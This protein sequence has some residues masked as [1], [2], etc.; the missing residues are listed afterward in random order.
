MTKYDL[1]I[2]GAGP[3][4]LTAAIYATRAGLSTLLVEK[5]V[6]GGQVNLANELENYPAEDGISG[7]EL[8]LKMKNQAEKYG[9]KFLFDEIASVDSSKKVVTQS[10]EEIEA[11]AVI[12]AVGTKHRELG[13]PSEQKFIG[14]GVSYCAVCDGGF[15]KNKPV[16]VVGG[17]N[18]AF[19]DAIYLSKI[20]SQVYLIHRREGFRAEKVLVERAKNEKNIKFLL[21]YTV[22]EISGSTRVEGISISDKESNINQLD[23]NG[24]FVA[25][26]TV[27]ETEFLKD[28]VKV[29][30]SGYIET[31]E[32]MKTCCDGIFAIGDV[33]KKTTRQIITACADGATAVE[34][35]LAYLE[36]R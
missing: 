8:A 2:I 3:A 18:T 34:S 35:V 17:G 4:G 19:K 14:M 30:E 31:D 23:V 27:P 5:A 29:D 15:F 32:N 26:G 25:V 9:A 36:G 20:A 13:I 7:F 12:V 16:A 33:R 24:V 1:V 28:I 22:K 21:N 11:G 6:V 10:G